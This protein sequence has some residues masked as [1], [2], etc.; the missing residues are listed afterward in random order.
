MRV[1]EKGSSRRTMAPTCSTVIGPAQGVIQQGDS[2]FHRGHEHSGRLSTSCKSSTS[3][4]LRCS[5]G[6]PG[7]MDF[8]G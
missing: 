5:R 2:P 1:A 6:R 8:P 7:D 4:T 3:T